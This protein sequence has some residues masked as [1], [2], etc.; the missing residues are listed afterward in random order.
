[1]PPS[2]YGRQDFWRCVSKIIKLRIRCRLVLN[3]QHLC[4]RS[5]GINASRT[6][7]VG[8]ILDFHISSTHHDTLNTPEVRNPPTS[9]QAPATYLSTKNTYG[10]RLC[11]CL[12]VHRRSSCLNRRSSNDL[13][14]RT[15][16][17][18]RIYAWDNCA[19]RQ[20]LRRHIRIIYRQE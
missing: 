4:E 15:R 14:Y 8:D 16:M 20:K 7:H 2:S 9:P 13:R 3:F 18:G 5:L 10:F 19:V 17:G 12:V 1:M 6:R 11:R